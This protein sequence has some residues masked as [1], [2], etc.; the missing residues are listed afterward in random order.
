M[1]KDRP[2]MKSDTGKPD[3]DKSVQKI[4]VQIYE[5]QTPREAEAMIELGVDRMG[6]V[7]LSQEEWKV[8]EIREAM[9]TR[10]NTPVKSSLIPLFSHPDAV[11]RA[12]D[13][14][15]PDII[16]FC[17][18]FINAGGGISDVFGNLISL[19]EGF[20]KRFPEV[21]IMRSIPVG[22]EGRAD[23]VPSLEA[24]RLFEAV[25]DYF[26][27]DT[28]L[29][30]EKSSLPADQPEAGFVGITGKI[31]DWGMAAKV[32]ETSRIPVVLAGGISPV[33]VFD[34][35]VA[36]RPAGVDSCTHTNALDPKGN[37]IRFKKDPEKVRRLIE[38]V[39][40]AENEIK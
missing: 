33:N 15:A 3:G 37:P 36:V 19:Q 14:Y 12:V 28:F 7:V 26:L 22:Q 4:F 31:C 27:L 32:V 8:F 2:Q 5:I 9:G 11:Y 13:F 23:R 30:G 38:E 34:A 21:E 39:R 25:S 35:I 40:K 29:D 24:A 1:I 10:K 6:S 18:S 20:R 16:H 17:E